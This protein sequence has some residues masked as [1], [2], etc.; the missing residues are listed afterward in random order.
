[1]SSPSRGPPSF[2]GATLAG[3]RRTLEALSPSRTAGSDTEYAMGRLASRARWG[4]KS[5]FVR[6]KGNGVT[7][8]VHDLEGDSRVARLRKE[9]DCRDEVIVALQHVIRDLRHELENL[10]AEQTFAEFALEAPPRAC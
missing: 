9:L 3:S 6:Q 7:A 2:Y 8:A 1:M 5:P 4:Y 10:R